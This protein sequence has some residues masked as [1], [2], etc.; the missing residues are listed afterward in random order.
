MITAATTMRLAPPLSSP[1][2]FA[3]SS[4]SSVRV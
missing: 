2:R 3:H 1:L 4:S